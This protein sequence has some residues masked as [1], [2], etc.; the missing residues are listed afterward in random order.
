MGN[1]KVTERENSLEGIRKEKPKGFWVHKIRIVKKH[2]I[3]PFITILYFLTPLRDHFS[4]TFLFKFSPLF[5][6]SILIYLVFFFVSSTIDSTCN[7]LESVWVII[8]CFLSAYYYN[9]S[10]YN[11]CLTKRKIVK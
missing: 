5:H 3:G 4:S 9:L 2:N 11:L 10:Y 1:W 8:A 6:S 7:L